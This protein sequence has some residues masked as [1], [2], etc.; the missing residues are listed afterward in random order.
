MKLWN[1]QCGFKTLKIN[2]TPTQVWSHAFDYWHIVRYMRIYLCY[3]S[4][5][6]SHYRS[7]IITTATWISMKEGKL[8]HQDGRFIFCLSNVNIQD[9][10]CQ[11]FVWACWKLLSVSSGQGVCCCTCP[12]GSRVTNRNN[13]KGKFPNVWTV[14]RASIVI[15]FCGFEFFHTVS[16]KRVKNKYLLSTHI[17][18][19]LT[20]HLHRALMHRYGIFQSFITEALTLWKCI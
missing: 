6:C 20:A 18:L 12:G 1:S 13:V 10:F 2:Y 17:S 19:A 16:N 8:L 4:G 9:W 11:I 14:Q 5:P 15:V 7:S 3:T